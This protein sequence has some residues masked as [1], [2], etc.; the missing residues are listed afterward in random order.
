MKL[1]PNELWLFFDCNSSAHKKTR[2]LAYSITGH[3]NEFSFKDSRISKYMWIDI[4]QML[5]MSP[6]E[7]FDKSNP[8]YQAEFARHDYD[9]ASWLNILQ[10]NPC[11]VKAPIAIMDGHAVLCIRPKDIYKI[12]PGKTAEIW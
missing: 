8:K 7:L 9:D 5:S 3:V 2:A 6:K 10:K 12:A 11:M 1:H 4:L